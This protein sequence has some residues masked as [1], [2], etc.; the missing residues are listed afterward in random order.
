MDKAARGWLFRECR[1][2]YWRIAKWYEFDDLVQDGAMVH[3]KIVAR[4]PDVTDAPH[5]MA[6]FK[7]AFKNHVHDLAKKRTRS[8]VEILETTLGIRLHEIEDVPHFQHPDTSPTIATLPGPLQ[9]VLYAVRQFDPVHRRRADRSRETTNERLCRYAGV[10][11]ETFNALDALRDA[12]QGSK[13]V[14]V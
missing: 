11:P 9:G 6:L 14:A 10:N 13:T 8:V 12:L 5:R 4:Y 2:H 3:A 7:R 1:E